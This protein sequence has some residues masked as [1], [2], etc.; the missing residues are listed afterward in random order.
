MALACMVVG[1]IA[2]NYDAEAFANPIKLLDMPEVDESLLRWFML[3][4]MVGYYLL[5]I[6]VMFFIHRSLEQ[7]TAWASVFTSLG[8]GYVLIGAIGAATLAVTWPALLQRY[9]TASV[10]MQEVYR[11]DFQL[12]T[13][14]VVKGLWN[15]LEVLAG[16][17]WWLG[18]GFFAIRNRTLNV[19]TIVLGAACIVDSVGEIF[20]MPIVAEIGLNIYLLLGIIW[21]IWIGLLLLKRKLD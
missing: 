16:G 4:D 18:V 10:A 11:G 13:E 9:E 20:E 2:T 1:L 21:P 17:V 19:V 5:L 14:F 6:P 3:L 7:T 8:V 12:M 15:Y